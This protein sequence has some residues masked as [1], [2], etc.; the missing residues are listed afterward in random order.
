MGISGWGG[1][2]GVGVGWLCQVCKRLMYA[3]LSALSHMLAAAAA[4]VAVHDN[5]ASMA[6]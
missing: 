2:R 4:A 5:V 3:E 1:D 6:P